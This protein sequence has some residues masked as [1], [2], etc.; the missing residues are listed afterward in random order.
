MPEVI[1]APKNYAQAYAKYK[2]LDTASRGGNTE[3]R[4]EKQRV[5]QDIRVM[6]RE[7]ARAGTL[8]DGGK[9]VSRSDSKR[10]LQEEYVRRFDDKAEVQ[11]SVGKD[12]TKKEFKGTLRQ[13]HAKRLLKR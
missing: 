7:S 9:V 3:A 13:Y 8:L 4:K 6:E 11:V 2:E 1:E 5:M 12:D 10:S